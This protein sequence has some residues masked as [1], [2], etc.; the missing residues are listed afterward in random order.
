MPFFDQPATPATPGRPPYKDEVVLEIYCDPPV[1]AQHNARPF[2]QS[3]TFAP[4]KTIIGAG[5]EFRLTR[6]VTQITAT[7]LT[8]IQNGV[9]ALFVW[10]RV[11]YTD[12]FKE[13]RHFSFKC[14]AIGPAQNGLKLVPHTDG[15][16]AD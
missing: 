11:N 10:G 16:K 13:R 1:I 4:V 15:Y 12:S 3:S 2:N 8:S 14:I 5:S 9:C 7:D 6:F